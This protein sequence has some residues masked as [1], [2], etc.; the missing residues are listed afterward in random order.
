MRPNNG[1]HSYPAD[2]EFLVGRPILA[3]TGFAAG[4]D[5]P[6]SASAGS[7]ARPT[8]R[9]LLCG[10]DLSTRE[11]DLHILIDEDLTAAQIDRLGGLSEDGDHFVAGLAECNALGRLGSRCLVVVEALAGLGAQLG[12]DVRIVRRSDGR[13][14]GLDRR[15]R[16]A[17]RRR[18]NYTLALFSPQ[19]A[20]AL[21]DGLAHVILHFLEIRNPHLDHGPPLA[22]GP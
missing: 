13:E 8:K 5:A 3:A 9:Q 21:V 10:G 20:Q 4:W 19:V 7:I 12:L 14:G 18:R 16:G 6:E 15:N 11:S 2:T 22:V 1:L 17:R